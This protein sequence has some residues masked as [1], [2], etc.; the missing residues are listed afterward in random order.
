M[1]EL[2]HPSIKDGWFQELSPLW[3]GQAMSLKVKKILHVEK[4]KF[5]D[6]LVFESFKHGNVLVL[7]GAIQCVE[8]DEFAYQEMI[9]HL[10]MASHPNPKSVLV[11]GGGDGGVLREVLKHP[12]VERAVLCDI[13]E[14]VPRVS[15]LYLKGMA[16]GFDDPRVEVFI[17]DGFEFL[18]DRKGKG[19]FDVI[20]T[21]SSDPSDADA[22]E[23]SSMPADSLFQKDYF[24]L[25]RDNLAEGGTIATQGECIWL[26]L[27]LISNLLKEMKTV[28]ADY[29][30]NVTYAKTSIPTYPSGT[31]GFLMATKDGKRD[32]M[33]PLRRSKDLVLKPGQT[34]KYWNEKA[35]FAAFVMPEFAR[36][37]IDK[38]KSYIPGSENLAPKRILLLGSGLVAGPAAECV[39]RRPENQLTIACRTLATAKALAA[40]LSVTTAVSCISLDVTDGAALA[41]AVSTHDLIISLI[42]YTYHI[43]V[44]K[45]A[46]KQ[47]KDVVTT[48]YISPAI[49]EVEQEAK[50]AGVTIVNEIGLDPGV[51]HLWAMKG[52]REIKAE[53]GKVKGF[54]SYCGGLVAP[55]NA[56]NPLGYKFS[57]SARGALLALLNDAKF[58]SK[59]K[60]Y[61]VPG[62]ELMS[63][64]KPYYVAPGFAFVA[65]PNRDSTPFRELYGLGEECEDFVRGTMRYEGFCEFIE[66]I[67]KLGF[68]DD[69]EKDWLKGD[70]T[71]AQ[72]T[73]KSIGSNDTSESALL[74]AIK[75]RISNLPAFSTSPAASSNLEKFFAGLYWYGFLSSNPAKIVRSNMLDTLC[76]LFESKMSLEKGDRDLV[77]LQHKFI[78]ENADGSRE[79][80]TSTLID[81]GAPTG[82]IDGGSSSMARLVGVPC[83]IAVQLVLDGKL[84]RPGVW[85]PYEDWIVDPLLEETIK[86]GI[87]LKEE[88][89]RSFS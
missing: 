64:A 78:V 61:P 9:A 19:E 7:D 11:I 72:I 68:M 15:K 56:T 87:E 10:P 29:G 4:S 23:G 57:W 69:S 13:D 50:D 27:N 73:A 71:W 80:R 39:L 85:A 66:G 48:S 26:H 81:F 60:P 34:M 74:P 32:F 86:E 58:L 33:Y 40:E 83:G 76:A 65:Y 41:K 24:A 37:E 25:L 88:K 47:K 52:F 51:D 49:R 89:F 8:D 54:S 36:V 53:G 70:L 18:R 77:V 22:V 30:G 55:E 63:F 35:H 16:Q 59:G 6:V 12:T 79:T 46:I 1:S 44:I 21:D 28:F 43:L 3:P 17:G 42:P 62:T 14:A 75:E 31:I 20:I 5:Q 67:K 38:A 82:S 84:K 2:T 45:E